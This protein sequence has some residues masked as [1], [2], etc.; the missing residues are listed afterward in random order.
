MT[1]NHLY[2]D[3]I[4]SARDGV[5][6]VYKYSQWNM[7]ERNTLLLIPIADMPGDFECDDLNCVPFYLH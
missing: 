7:S 1:L 4:V 2:W 5:D 3:K 6:C